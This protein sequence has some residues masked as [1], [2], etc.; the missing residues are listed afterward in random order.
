MVDETLFQECD[1]SL[2]RKFKTMSNEA[3]AIISE[4]ESNGN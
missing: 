2:N 4:H 1:Y 3:N